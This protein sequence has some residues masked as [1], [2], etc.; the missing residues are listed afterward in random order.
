MWELRGF[1]YRNVVL[2]DQVEVDTQNVGLVVVNGKNLDANIKSVTNGAGKSLL[3]N[4]LA[5]VIFDSVP[6]A[7]TKRGSKKDFFQKESA[8]T[9]RFRNN[10]Q[11][12]EVT[13]TASSYS[14]TV[15]GKE[16]KSLKEGRQDTAKEWIAKFC[17]VSEP[18]FYS[19]VYIHTQAAHPFQR[20]KPSERLSY[21][22]E[23]FSLNV[24]DKLRAHFN[25]LLA[26]AKEKVKVVEIYAEDLRQAEEVIQGLEYKDTS[27]L[28]QKVATLEAQQSE[29]RSELMECELQQQ[30]FLQ[31]KSI[32][33]KLKQIGFIEDAESELDDIDVRVIAVKKWDKYLT[34]KEEFD[35]QKSKLEAKILKLKTK[36][37]KFDVDELNSD[38]DELESVLKS[39]KLNV[40][41]LERIEARLVQLLK[42]KPKKPKLSE[43]E[44]RE[45]IEVSKRTI[46]MCA[47]LQGEAECPTCG[48]D[49]DAK[50]LATLSARAESSKEDAGEA[51]R[52]YAFVQSRNDLTEARDEL[53]VKIAAQD[54]VIA[55]IYAKYNKPEEGLLS[56]LSSVED[57]YDQYRDW[58][59]AKAELEELQPPTKV[60]KTSDTLEELRERER[61]LERYLDLN[62]QL[63]EI[64]NLPKKDPSS[65]LDDLREEL[66]AIMPLL[67]KYA[68]TR[69]KTLIANERYTI[70][71]ER[72]EELR[73]KISGLGD[74]I[75][76]KRCLEMLVKAYSNNKLKLHAADSVLKALESE[77]NALAPLVFP[78]PVKFVL[79]T[80]A[81]GVSAVAHFPKSKIP[82]ADIYTLSGAESNCFRLLFAL[83]ILVFVPPE[84]RPN[85]MILDEPES[86]C[87]ESVRK[88]MINEFLPKLQSIVP[89][90]FWITPLDVDMFG[91]AQKWTVVKQ[92]GKSKLEIR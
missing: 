38:C 85:F 43:D 26:K 86:N 74:V 28:D 42:D 11:D 13:K 64:K 37:P 4:P 59:K 12:L 27:K 83:A 53:S 70:T 62:D 72:I 6:L 35:K 76:E 84:R 10:N 51:L 36:K 5:D 52:Y 8:T 40:E 57:Q 22:T 21:I 29:I 69:S 30:S 48:Q 41:N 60:P 47:N 24:Y 77:L 33:S 88:H 92:N 20:A 3:F 78:E 66:D 82:P 18:E 2:F 17:P 56:L 65:K 58:Q 81:Q 80:N 54:Q 68:D 7:V 15:D 34:Q 32:R 16:I 25:T 9:F 55:A 79:S 23:I 61:E 44:A 90:I 91:T 31:A 71:K 1:N 73:S 39:R 49:L 89:N 75:E 19:F 14:I 67:S 45:E 46:K 50:H 87:G 63:A